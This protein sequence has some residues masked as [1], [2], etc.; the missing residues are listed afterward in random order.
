MNKLQQKFNWTCTRCGVSSTKV[1]STFIRNSLVFFLK[2]L[3]EFVVIQ[4]KG[5]SLVEDY[6]S[7]TRS[8]VNPSVNYE[9]K[10][11]LLSSTVNF[12]RKF[13]ELLVEVLRTSTWSSD[14]F[15]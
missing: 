4:I 15:Y 10:V 8:S 12:Y 1:G 11:S 14:N 7:C 3:C 2:K 5:T 9:Q 13:G 6:W